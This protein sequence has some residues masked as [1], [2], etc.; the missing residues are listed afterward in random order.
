MA[1]KR[2]R[3]SLPQPGGPGAPWAWRRGHVP[4]LRLGRAMLT[5]PQNPCEISVTSRGDSMAGVP[6]P[7]HAFSSP[8]CL[9][10][11][12]EQKQYQNQVPTSPPLCLPACSK[13]HWPFAKSTFGGGRGRACRVKPCWNH[14]LH[15]QISTHFSVIN[16]SAM[17][18]LVFLYS[19]G[20][21]IAEVPG[22]RI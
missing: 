15:I 8:C 22:R 13:I 21:L 11:H 5:L 19:L 9:L 10:H 7:R 6:V 2:R 17:Y 20:K 16:N 14:L 18:I 3:S 12:V 1:P 4:E